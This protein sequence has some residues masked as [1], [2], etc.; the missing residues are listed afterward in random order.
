MYDNYKCY[1]LFLSERA[2]KLFATSEDVIDKFESINKANED[3][4]R[5]AL[6]TEVESKMNTFKVCFCFFMI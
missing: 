6:T 4:G 5:W 1:R 3:F 2:A